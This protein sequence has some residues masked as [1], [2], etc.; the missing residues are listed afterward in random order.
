VVVVDVAVAADAVATAAVG[1]AVI[2]AIVAVTADATVKL[3]SVRFLPNLAAQNSRASNGRI[4]ICLRCAVLSL[5][6]HAIAARS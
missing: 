3:S 5:M 2:A 1:E 6:I 4:G